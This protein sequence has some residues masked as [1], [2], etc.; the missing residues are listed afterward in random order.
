VNATVALGRAFRQMALAR[1]QR[2]MYYVGPVGRR[3]TSRELPNK[4]SG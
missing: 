3:P 4:F 2:L 1:R